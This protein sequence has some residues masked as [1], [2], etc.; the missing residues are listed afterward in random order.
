ML[1]GV[2]RVAAV[3]ALMAAC[4]GWAQR[5]VLDSELQQMEADRAAR[6]PEVAPGLHLPAE[7]MVVAVDEF[8][9]A[10]ELVALE[11][12]DSGLNKNTAHNI[13]RQ[14]V[15]PLASQHQLAELKGV[16]AAVQLHTQR[17]VF[18]VRLGENLPVETPEDAV[19]VDTR[20]AGGGGETRVE[21]STYVIVRADVRKDERVVA[22]FKLTLTGK[23]TREENVCEADAE[24]LPGGHWMRLT[25]RHPLLEGEYAVMEV[26]D[27]RNVNLSV[28]DFGVHAAAAENRDVMRPEVRKPRGLQ[29]R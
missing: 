1:Q 6:S 5:P 8:G 7:D 16:S 24:V 15:N 29:T 4:A 21:P 9:G 25:P 19:R 13:L 18:Y 20:G 10:V 22:S 14:T 2:G 17:P 3:A 27:E 28:W 26:L 23:V 11:Q 12:T